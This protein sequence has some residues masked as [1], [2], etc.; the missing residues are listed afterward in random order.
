MKFSISMHRKVLTMLNNEELEQMFFI[1]EQIDGQIITE[2]FNTEFQQEEYDRE[3]VRALNA[4]E[5]IT[6]GLT[7]V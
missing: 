6:F 4:H 5:L 7:K 2:L 3:L 1:K